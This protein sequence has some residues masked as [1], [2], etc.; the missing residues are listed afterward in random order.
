MSGFAR[1]EDGVTVGEHIEGTPAWWNG[2]E[3]YWARAFSGMHLEWECCP[4]E[5]ED[6]GNMLLL[7]LSKTW[8]AGTRKC[9]E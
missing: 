3:W 5:N 1:G 4:V 7:G 9:E 6:A 8:F 2:T